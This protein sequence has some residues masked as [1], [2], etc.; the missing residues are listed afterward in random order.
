MFGSKHLLIA[1]L[2]GTLGISFVSYSA[3]RQMGSDAGIFAFGIL[4]I[5]VSSLFGSFIASQE[6]AG[7]LDD[8][9]KE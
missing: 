3:F 2:I 7:K 8:P 4:L 1:F 6:K 5:W 9:D